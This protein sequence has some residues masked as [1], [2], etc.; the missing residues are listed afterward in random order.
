MVIKFFEKLED[1]SNNTD[2]VSSFD[3]LHQPIV[4]KKKIEVSKRINH[5]NESDVKQLPIV[6]PPA[7]PLLLGQ[8]SI[9]NAS[10]TLSADLQSR[11]NFSNANNAASIISS[12]GAHAPVVKFNED[13]LL[14]QQAKVV[15]SSTTMDDDENVGLFRSDESKLKMTNTFKRK[16]NDE[17]DEGEEPFRLLNYFNQSIIS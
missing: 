5:S 11:L 6:E 13:S 1:A 14:S 7:K 3:D 15:V 17:D 8:T 16:L 4:D 9:T 2:Q 10:S 12:G